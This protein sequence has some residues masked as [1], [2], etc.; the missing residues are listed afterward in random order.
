MCQWSHLLHVCVCVCVRVCVCVCVRVCVSPTMCLQHLSRAPPTQSPAFD[1]LLAPCSDSAAVDSP[2]LLDCHPLLMAS[3]T[4]S[5]HHSSHH[6]AFLHIIPPFVTSL[7]TS[8]LLLL[9]T[10]HITH[11]FVTSLLISSHHSSHH[12]FRHSRA[13]SVPCL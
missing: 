11:P 8:L 13:P 12:S 5:S 1:K 4:L 6:S 7:V 9:I 10:P 2:S 3:L